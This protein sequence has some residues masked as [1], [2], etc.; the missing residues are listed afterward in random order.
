[1]WN[2]RG[3]KNKI[4]ELQ[5]ISKDYDILILTETKCKVNDY[6]KIPGFKCYYDTE[7]NEGE[8]KE[9]K[10]RKKLKN[11]FKKQ[12]NV[13]N[14][15]HIN[16]SSNNNIKF[17]NDTNTGNAKGNN[18]LSFCSN[19]YDNDNNID[20]IIDLVCKNNIDINK[21]NNNKHDQYSKSTTQNDPE[22]KNNNE[23]KVQYNQN[24]Y[25]SGGVLLAIRN[26]IKHEQ[27]VVNKKNISK[28]KLY[29][30]GIK[31]GL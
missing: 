31:P 28:N 10:G 27:L 25:G 1:M 4:Q 9:K 15:T 12:N 29:Q 6:I 21:D 8:K 19:N 24:N 23:N 16:N 13:K 30:V 20:K 2:C 14:T 7:N 11:T 22:V 3:I 17:T 26:N 18:N 5:Q